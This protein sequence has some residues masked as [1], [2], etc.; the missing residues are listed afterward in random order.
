MGT[1]RGIS[2][3]YQCKF[4]AKFAGKDPNQVEFRS[5]L[6][7]SYMKFFDTHPSVEVWGY[8]QNIIPYVIE[9]EGQII[10]P[11][12]R[13]YFVDFFVKFREKDGKIKKYLIEIKP[14]TFTQ[15]PKVPKNGPTKAYQERLLEY[16]KNESKWTTAAKY[17]AS[18]D[19]VFKVL[20]EDDLK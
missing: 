9:M 20:T 18:H 3:V 1:H 10:D 4:P 8:E 7:R 19:A 5:L 2:G 15:K 17:C 16:Y 14:K 13:R 6:E 11:K 12:V